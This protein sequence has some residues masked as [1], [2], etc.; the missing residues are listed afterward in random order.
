MVD[1]SVSYSTRLH[2]VTVSRALINTFTLTIPISEINYASRKDAIQF[3]LD[4]GLTRLFAFLS[5]SVDHLANTSVYL[6]FDDCNNWISYIHNT[7]TQLLRILKPTQKWDVL[8]GSIRL[9]K[10]NP[11][12]GVVLR[13]DTFLRCMWYTARYSRDCT[14]IDTRNKPQCT[15][16]HTPLD[17]V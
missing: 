11:Q 15:Q 17:V 7:L 14:F 8:S 4:W 9:L 6:I 12:N 2:K 13:I 1:I 10:R 3:S 5:H 16:L